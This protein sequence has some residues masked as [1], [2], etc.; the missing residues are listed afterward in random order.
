[1]AGKATSMIEQ[2]QAV[3]YRQNVDWL[4]KNALARCHDWHLAQDLVQET[5]IKLFRSWPDRAPI[6]TSGRAYAAKVLINCHLDE[7]R[8]RKARVQEISD[9]LVTSIPG[10]PIEPM[11]VPSDLDIE[12]RRAVRDLPQQQRDLVY[13][14]YYEGLSLAE[15]AKVMGLG[16]KTVHNYHSLAKKKLGACLSYLAN[17]AK[18]QRD[19]R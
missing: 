15:A 14:V 13:H 7:I 9:D 12:V 11:Q 3:F 2:D 19:E 6:I 10:G 8:R 16:P 18:E 1:M 5:F 17:D 4:L